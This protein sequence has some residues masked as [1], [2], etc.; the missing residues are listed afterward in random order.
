VTFQTFLS[1]CY[2]ILEGRGDLSNYTSSLLFARDWDCNQNKS[3]TDEHINAGLKQC[4]VSLGLKDL[5]WNLRL[6]SSQ[7]A[8]LHS[9]HV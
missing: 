2:Q 6:P 4:R 9:S 7:P 1:L 5:A 3:T 8:T